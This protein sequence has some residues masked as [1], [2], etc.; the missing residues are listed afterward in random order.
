M[1]V[2]DLDQEMPG[3]LYPRVPETF[4]PLEPPARI[5]VVMQK[6][7]AGKSTCATCLACELALLG[8]RV[9]LWDVDP[10]NGGSTSW[11]HPQTSGSD[12]EPPNLR[13][14]FQGSASPDEV[15]YS[16]SVPG[17]SIVPSY[18]SLKQVEL[19]PPPGIEQG[20]AWGIDNTG[21]PFDVE[22]TD[23][24]PSL[25]QLTIAAMVAAP[26]LI[27]PF[28]ASGLDLNAMGDLNRTVAMVKARLVPALRVAAILLSEVTRTNLTREV[29]D[30]YGEAYPD[31]IV[32]GIRLNTK[33]REASLPNIL[34]PLHVYA[35]TA[36]VRQDFQ[37][38]AA[39]IIKGAP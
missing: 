38:L 37:Y 22:I 1:S 32:M 24:G 26:N 39:H 23:C 36:T 20:I 7:G 17:L 10:Q 13:D 18:T 21:D 12:G 27:I 14:M 34:Q 6:G 35:P 33:A 3:W 2:L 9:R 31:S 11:L 30:S 15:T 4:Q 29:Y 8:L 16:T 5:C 25:G 19:S 28:K